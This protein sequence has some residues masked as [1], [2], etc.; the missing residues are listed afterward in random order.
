MELDLLSA[1]DKNIFLFLNSKNSPVC[2]NI[3]VWASKMYLWIPLYIVIIFVILKFFW[4]RQY[5]LLNVAL[6]STFIITLVVI[7]YVVYPPI[8]D[9]SIHRVRPC[10]NPDLIA[11]VHTVGEE[12]VD[13]FDFFVQNACFGFALS[14]FLFFALPVK[15]NWLKY[16]I[17][18]WAFLLSYSR[19]Y[20]GMHYPLNVFTAIITGVFTGFIIY[21]FYRY[22]KNSFLL[23]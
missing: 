16:L 13:V 12:S 5:F 10:F 17:I 19:I 1:I 23:I 11:T 14:T 8:F 9:E 6:I 21:N 4:K 7:N 18:A 15:Y 22:L 2:D 20:L 3:M